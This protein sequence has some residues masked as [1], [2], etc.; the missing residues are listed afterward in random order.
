MVPVYTDDEL[1]PVVSRPQ[2]QPSEGNAHRNGP[3]VHLIRRNPDKRHWKIAYMSRSIADQLK[4]PQQS[5]SKNG[6]KQNGT[7]KSRRST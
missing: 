1:S 3:Y 5:T 2:I 7:G 4:L 6:Q